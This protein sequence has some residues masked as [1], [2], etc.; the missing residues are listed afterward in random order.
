MK[1]VYVN[2][3]IQNP[4]E[5]VKRFCAN[6]RHAIDRGLLLTK[7]KKSN[8]IIDPVKNSGNNYEVY[9]VF[10]ISDNFTIVDEQQ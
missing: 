7:D 2:S 1:K 3:D 5:V 10:A 6:N 4:V 8:Y 9:T